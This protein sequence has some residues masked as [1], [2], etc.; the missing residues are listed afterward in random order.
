M[1]KLQTYTD[2]VGYR[3]AFD[4][5]DAYAYALA[6]WISGDDCLQVL[7]VAIAD[8]GPLFLEASHVYATRKTSYREISHADADRTVAAWRALEAEPVTAENRDRLALYHCTVA[9]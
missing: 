6:T 1:N 9:A 4:L 7:R 3:R 5:S 2:R 8:D